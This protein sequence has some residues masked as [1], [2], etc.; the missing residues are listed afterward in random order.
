MRTLLALLLVPGLAL[1]EPPG[2]SDEETSPPTPSAAEAAPPATEPAAAVQPAA[3]RAPPRWGLLVDAGL[4]DGAVVS[5]V[6]RFAE[7]LRASFGLGYNGAGWGVRGTVGWLPIRWAISPTLNLEYGYYWQA[8]LTWLAD[9]PANGI[10]PEMRPLLESVGY[11]YASALLGLEIG[12]PN[13]FS[14]SISGGLT[15]LWTTVH[16]VGEAVSSGAGSTTVIEIQDPSLRATAP[17]LKVGF[18]LYF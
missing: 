6:Y 11:S 12:S 13:G 1:A 10:P 2:V 16:G 17:T 7:P 3:I 4:P 9:D 18:L 5:A 14:F 15:Y 8:D